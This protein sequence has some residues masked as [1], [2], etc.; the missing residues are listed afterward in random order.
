MRRIAQYSV[1]GVPAPPP[2]TDCA[3]RVARGLRPR[4]P[5]FPHVL[6]TILRESQQNRISPKNRPRTLRIRMRE[7][8][9]AF[10]W[11]TDYSV[12]QRRWEGWG[13]FDTGFG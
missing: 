3:K 13:A 5:S 11:R 1:H 12:I 8:Y 9:L 6:G 7:D 4:Q 10:L 2:S